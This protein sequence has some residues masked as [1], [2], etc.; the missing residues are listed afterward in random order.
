[1]PKGVF[2][3]KSLE[4]RFWEKVSPEP[5]SGCWLWLGAFD[6]GGYGHIGINRKMRIAH[7]VSYEMYKDK[8]P[9]GQNVCH[10]CDNRACV[11]PDHLFLGT[12]QEN[13]ADRNI[14][15]RQSKG[16]THGPAKLTEAKVVE[17]RSAK[18]VSQRALAAQ[19]GVSRSAV[20]DILKGKN[21]AHL[22]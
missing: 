5:N 15:G 19:Y 7:R 1:M 20:V 8:I 3:R 4:V 6:T 2:E 14:K 18:G 22:A 12:H 16:S 13:M 21:W 17:I 9:E 11:N 10:S